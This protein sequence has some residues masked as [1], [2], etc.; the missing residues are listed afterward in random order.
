[1][2]NPGVTY[3]NVCSPTFPLGRSSSWLVLRVDCCRMLCVSTTGAA[4]VTVMVS[5]IAPTVIVTFTDAVNPVG[6]WM[7]SRFTVENPGSV[8]VT[9]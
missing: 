1:M 4:P 6:S 9:V 3:A 7:P 5:S 8:K 2:A